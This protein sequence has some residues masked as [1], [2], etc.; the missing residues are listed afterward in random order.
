MARKFKEE[1]EAKE[2]KKKKKEKKEKEKEKEKEKRKKKERKEK[3]E[4]KDFEVVAAATQFYGGV[5]QQDLTPQTTHLIIPTPFGVSFLLFLL[6]LSLFLSFPFIFYF[7]FLSILSIFLQNSIIFIQRMFEAAV[8]YGGIHIVNPSWFV[9]SIER[10]KIMSEEDE[11]YRV[12]YDKY[13]VF[14][15]QKY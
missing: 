15:L 4:K 7:P 5:Y 3:K 14:V 12:S 11:K 1:E 2:K 8:K 13:V 10:K 9:D 6:F